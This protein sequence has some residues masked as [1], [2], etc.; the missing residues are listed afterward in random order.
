MKV[1]HQ[2]PWPHACDLKGIGPTPPGTII[3][4][5]TCG[6]LYRCNGNVLNPSDSYST[7]GA[8]E[9]LEEVFWRLQAWVDKRFERRRA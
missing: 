7:W 5:P 9:P 3:Q 4:C 1:V 8:L 2:P 6:R